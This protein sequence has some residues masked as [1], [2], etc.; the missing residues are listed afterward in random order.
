MTKFAVIL[1]AAGKSSRFGDQHTK[2]VFTRVHDKPLWLYSAERFSDHPAVS[3]ILIVISPD[4]KE[5]FNEKFSAS[6]AMLGV[7]PVL[8]GEQRA[9]SV[10][11]A[12]REIREDIPMVA[13]HDAARP[14]ITDESIAGVFQAALTHQAA[15]LA[16]PVHATIKRASPEGRVEAT[17]PRDRLWLAQTP[18][19]F[20]KELLNEAYDKNPSA[21]AAT[22]EASL[23]ESIGKP[24]Y[25]VEG[26]PLNIKVT[27]K[28][29]LKLAEFGLKK[30]PPK[31]PFPF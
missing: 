1:A 30:R 27:T 18:Q 16:T 24:V 31:N 20:S 8:G 21:S 19:V 23:V 4:D 28:S 22:D 10:R 29:D 12:L 25:L 6:A 2:K 5:L 13:V 9:D 15:L 11:N 7:Q 14:C 26:D 17:I 3:Q